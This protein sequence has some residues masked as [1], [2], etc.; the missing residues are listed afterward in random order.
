MRV[1]ARKLNFLKKITFKK[2][3]SNCDLY[4]NIFIRKR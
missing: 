2:D 4:E 1:G 3:K